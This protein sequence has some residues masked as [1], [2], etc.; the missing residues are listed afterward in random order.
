MK[1]QVIT[2]FP[3]MI[4]ATISEGVIG[5]ARNKSLVQID[6]INPREFAIDNHKTVDDRPFGGGDGMVMMAEPL[7]KALREAIEQSSKDPWIVYLTPQGAPLDQKK[8]K[9]L[10]QNE[11][12][13]L[14]C[15]RYGGIDQR[16]LNQ[17]IDEEISLGD[18]V[19]SGGELAASVVIDSVS[20]QL[21]GVLGH[22]DSANSDSF[23][24][25]LQGL[26][27]APSFTRPREWMGEAAP[28]VL[29]SGNHSKI[30]KWKSQVSWL[31]TL[32]K[33]P[34]LALDKKLSRKEYLELQKFWQGLGPSEKEVLGLL[35]LTDADLELLK[36]DDLSL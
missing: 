26:L 9:E 6:C 34:D 2:L 7:Q 19:L 25:K 1:F 20:R 36:N 3:Q 5:Q 29:L 32:L 15:G 24:E 22:Q 12:L 23:S 13:V 21:P 17:F 18:Y 16:V 35:A 14:V 11:N 30:E 28:E 31:V 27:E 4:E 10:A 8:V 33:R